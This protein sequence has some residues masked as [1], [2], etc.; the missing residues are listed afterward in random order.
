MPRCLALQARDLLRFEAGEPGVQPA[1]VLVS[2]DLLKTEFHSVLSCQAARTDVGGS[3]GFRGCGDA[4][5]PHHSTKGA[6]C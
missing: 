5:L 4:E 1:A 6:V 2:S 3:L